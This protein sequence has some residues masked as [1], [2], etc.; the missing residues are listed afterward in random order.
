MLLRN[1]RKILEEFCQ[2]LSGFDVVEQD[3]KRYA[4]PDE[5]RCATHDF[6]VA[7]NDRL[8]AIHLQL[9]RR[10][11]GYTSPLLI[12]ANPDC[13]QSRI[14]NPQSRVRALHSKIVATATSLNLRAV[15]KTAIARSGMDV[16]ARAVSG[17]TSSAK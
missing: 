16:P 8:L 7:V 5:D 12:R 17:L 9:P 15:L 1:R 6:G 3:L 11:A 14:P 2:R 13:N 10:Q 4:R